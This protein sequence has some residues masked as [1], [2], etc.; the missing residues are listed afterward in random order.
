MQGQLQFRDIA[1]IIRLPFLLLAPV[2]IFLAASLAIDDTG[3]IDSGTLSIILVCSVFAHIAVNALNEYQD[4]RSGLDL[5]TQRTSFSGGSGT[6]P[7]KPGLAPVALGI[8]S[9]ALAVTVVT[10]LV[11]VIQHGYALLLP[12]LIVVSLIILYTNVINRFP[13]LCLLSPG[14]GFGLVMVGGSYY[15]LTGDYN[16][17]VFLVSLIPFFLSN[18]LLLLN[19]FPDVRAD[20]DAGRNHVTIHY[21]YETGSRIYLLFL[22]LAALALV[23]SVALGVLPSLS[24]AGLLLIAAGYP[25]YLAASRYGDDSD[26]LVPYMARNVGMVLSMP[27]LIGAT[28]YT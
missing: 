3:R 23:L 27:V 22:G 15:V 18:N 13:L 12:G 19:Q 25:V 28:L 9:I 5:S 2:C 4:F 26:G 7:N 11:L 20:R 14:V 17:Q 8:S 21:G 16:W 6:L 24:L 10:G 1:G